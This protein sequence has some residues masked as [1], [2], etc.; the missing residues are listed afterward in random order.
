MRTVLVWLSS[1]I[2][3]LLMPVLT[4]AANDVDI[5]LLLKK[6][7]RVLVQRAASD[8][9]SGTEVGMLFNSGDMVFAGKNSLAAVMFTDDKS[10][11]KVRDNSS[12]LIKGKRENGTILK[13][14]Q[15]LLGQIWFKAVNMKSELIIETP[16]GVA[17]IKGTEFYCRIERNGATY[18][19]VIDGTVSFENALGKIL[20]KRGETGYATANEAPVVDE[21]D[22]SQVPSWGSEDESNHKLEIEFKDSEGNNKRLKIDY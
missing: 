4:R 18:I 9:W 8:D 19:F 21:S 20:I 2:F 5:A 10:L 7:G 3:I 14:I 6:V 15:V 13:R 11:V 17:T 1:L 12:F 16:S 22:P